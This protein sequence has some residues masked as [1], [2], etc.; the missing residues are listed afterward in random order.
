MIWISV[1]ICLFFYLSFLYFFYCY[2]AAPRPTLGHFR[3]ESLTNLMLITVFVQFRPE[4]HREP[5]NEVG[6]L[7][8]VKRLVG[9]EPGTFRLQRFKP[10]GHSPQI[11]LQVSS[12][13]LSILK[14]ALSFRILLFF[15]VEAFC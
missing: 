14:N 5:S 6:S 10:L 9:F 12:Q 8:L 11:N 1:F 13:R 4:G 3:R 15:G 2:L 7:N